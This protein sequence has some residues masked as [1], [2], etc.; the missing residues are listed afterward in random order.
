MLHDRLHQP[1]PKAMGAIVFMDEYI[2]QIGE[3]REI[4]DNPGHTDLLLSVIDAEDKRILIGAFR[5][6]VW[7]RTAQ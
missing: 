6:F 4:R 1:F 2:A 7:T 3:D 5:S